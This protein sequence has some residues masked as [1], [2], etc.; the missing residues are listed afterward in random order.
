MPNRPKITLSFLSETLSRCAPQDARIFRVDPGGAMHLSILEAS[1][2]IALELG[3][4]PATRIAI[5]SKTLS[6]TPASPATLLEILDDIIAR[7]IGETL[8]DPDLHPLA[9]LREAVWD[10]A[11]AA[12][13]ARV[14]CLDDTDTLCVP[15][16]AAKWL[17]LA[18]GTVSAHISG[19]DALQR[20]EQERGEDGFLR[21]IM[22]GHVI[23]AA[24]LK[25]LAGALRGNLA[26][27]NGAIRRQKIPTL[28]AEFHA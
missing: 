11:S 23:E 15:A 26:A 19:E 6:I 1:E 27:D 10:L 14:F 5:A 2:M 9:S 21:V 4:K 3:R 25:D 13:A 17:C 22:R 8:V 16:N 20:A 24:G 28:L 12:G 7:D 18:Q